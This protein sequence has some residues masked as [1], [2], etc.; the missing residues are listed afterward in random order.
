MGLFEDLFGKEVAEAT[1]P[2]DDSEYNRLLNACIEKVEEKNRLLMEKYGFGSFGRWDLDQTK[3][4]LVFSDNGVTKLVCSIALL[5]SF[6]SSSGTWM[7]AWANSSIS[8]SLSRDTLTVKE[9]GELNGV[10][11]LSVK[12]TPATEGEAW[13]LAALACQIL[14][15]LGLYRG[16]TGKG[17]VIMMIKDILPS[18]P[19]AAGQP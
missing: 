10:S 15:G 14:G 11:D 4:D 5:G 2:S 13:A 1:T 12:K 7:W 19:A 17:F 8:E 3:G 18:G 6:S 9:Y 16:P